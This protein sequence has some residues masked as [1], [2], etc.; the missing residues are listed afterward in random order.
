MARDTK[1]TKLVLLDRDGVINEDSDAY[2]KSVDEWRP[3]PGSLEAIARLCQA[4]FTVAVVSNQSGLAR[5]LFDA[6]TLEA[7]HAEMERQVE[8][9]GGRLA[10]VFHCPHAPEAGC[11]CR[12]PRPGLLR[13][14]EAQLGLSVAGATLVGDK[15]DDLELARRGGCRPVLVRTGKGA[16]TEREGQ[17]LRGADVFDDLEA[18]VDSLLAG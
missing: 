7:I 17:G 1:P 10:G 13:Q 3:I 5:G 9:A 16:A 4:G 6:A 14:V 18:V 8:A 12:K 2:V 11:E 15:P